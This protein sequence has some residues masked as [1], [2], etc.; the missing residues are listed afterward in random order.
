[1]RREMRRLAWI[2]YAI[3]CL[4][5]GSIGGVLWVVLFHAPI[6]YVVACFLV[7]GILAI[8]ALKVR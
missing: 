3:G 1:M 7:I 2:A 5:L 4:L 8:V 6:W